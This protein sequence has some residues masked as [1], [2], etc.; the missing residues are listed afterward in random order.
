MSVSLVTSIAG[1]YPAPDWAYSPSETYPEYAFG[2]LASAPNPVYAGVRRLL[3]ERGLDKDRLGSP[4]WNPLRELV[5]EGSRVFVLCNF[6]Y[7]RRL[8]ES[9]RDLQAK[10]IHGSVLRAL[11]DYVLLAVGPE[12]RVAFGNS[13]LQSCRFDRV[14]ADTGADR[15]EAFYREQGLPVRVR[16]LRL[17]VVSRDL[18]GRITDVDHRDDRDG[19]EFDLGDRSLLAPMSTAG[20]PVFR[21]S[22][23]DPR[24]IQAFHQGGRHRY[25]IHR[26]VLESEVVI[27][28]SKL[29]THEKVGITCGLK[30]FVGSV[31]HK[32]CLAHHRFGSPRRGGDEYPDSQAFL[33]PVSRYFDWVNRRGPGAPLQALAQIADRTL[34]R[35]WRRS[36]LI[37]P[38]AWHGNDTAWRMSLDL[39]RIAYYGTTAGT[40]ESRPQRRHL[41]LIDGIV[42]GEGEG[43]LSP[44]PVAGGTLIF[45]DDVALTDRIACRLMGFDP[46][47][48]PLIREAFRLE[49]WPITQRHEAPA[50]CVVDGRACLESE[51]RPVLSRA[52]VPPAG[53]KALLARP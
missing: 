20:E 48:I 43:P 44:S 15:V 21:I 53:W 41:S 6:V 25:V 11:I 35:V 14:L 47:R 39:A 10:C 24:R 26:D 16:D 23:Y 22:D 33:E 1:E 12:G 7:Q 17:F 38:G 18:L 50:E 46:A 42:A 27:S 2:R 8:Q 13:S 49:P 5:P 51:L 52:F 32:E 36:G 40:L 30:G 4:D 37:G 45:G 34:R 9:V 19:V 3:A 28:L 31:G 29:K